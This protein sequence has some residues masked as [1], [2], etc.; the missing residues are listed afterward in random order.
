MFAD[1]LGQL[2][3]VA[4]FVQKVIAFIKPTY[5]N[6]E[7]QKYIDMAL[8]IVTS[9]LLC[10]AWGIDVFAVAGIEFAMNWL[11]PVLTG[12]VAGLGSNVLN[13]LLALL[14]MWK[15]QKKADLVFKSAIADEMNEAAQPVIYPEDSQERGS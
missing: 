3:I 11:A 4:V 15:K 7:Y 1:V 10:L 13:D 2:S 9:A 6:H 14:E 12:V 8:S 5:E